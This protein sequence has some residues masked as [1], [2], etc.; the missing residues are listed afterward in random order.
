MK[1]ISKIILVVAIVL[2]SVGCDQVSKSMASDLLQH[3]PVK[4]YLNGLVRFQ[5]AENT[6]GFLS[7]GS[8]LHPL[9]RSTIAVLVAFFIVFG[10]IVLVLN[11]HKLSTASIVGY[12][13]FLAGGCGNSIDR[14]LNEGRVT[15][16]IILGTNWLQTGVFNFADVFITVGV[17]LALAGNIFERKRKLSAERTGHRS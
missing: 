17:V 1:R 14:L 15:D 5:Y 10:L 2:M 12:S 3:A 16:F 9:L 13:L 4:S 8:N 6:G 11:V 7:I